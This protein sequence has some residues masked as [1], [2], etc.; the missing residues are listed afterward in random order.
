MAALV[1]KENQNK[2]DAL[3]VSWDSSLALEWGA[4][5]A[6]KE[7]GV[8]PGVPLGLWLGILTRLPERLSPCGATRDPTQPL[9]FIRPES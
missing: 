4:V 1:L 8:R 5:G 6:G 3:G 2:S 7:A 9:I